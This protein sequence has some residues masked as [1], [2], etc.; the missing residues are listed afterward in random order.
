M[1]DII[2]E[3]LEDAAT[4]KTSITATVLEVWRELL[5]NINNEEVTKLSFAQVVSISGRHDRLRLSDVTTYALT[6]Y[7]LLAEALT[8]VL[9]EIASE[10]ESLSRGG[11]D[12]AE[13]NKAHY[14]NIITQ[15]QIMFAAEEASFLSH[16]PK[17]EE[18]DSVVYMAALIDA[19]NFVLGESGLVAHLDAINFAFNDEDAA[20]VL[21]AVQDA[22]E[23][24]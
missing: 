11:D 7:E 3:A 16:L 5:S 23:E 10:P 19:M 20:A 6:F 4:G 15:W 22:R 12:D 9:D 18:Q 17:A 1:T 24:G 2:D 14:L 8:I 13:D 21:Q